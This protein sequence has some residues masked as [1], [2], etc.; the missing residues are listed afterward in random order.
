MA[1]QTIAAMA[2]LLAVRGWTLFVPPYE[3]QANGMWHEAAY[4]ARTN[5]DYYSLRWEEAHYFFGGQNRHY[6]VSLLPTILAILMKTLPNA[7]SVIFCWRFLGLLFAAVIA[8]Q[9]YH[10]ARVRASAATTLLLVALLFT[11]PMFLV[12]V[13]LAGMELPVIVFALIASWYVMRERYVAASVASLLSFLMKATGGLVTMALLA[14]LG[15]LI[16]L[17]RRT[18]KEWSGLLASGTVLAIQMLALYFG[19]DTSV[20]RASFAW[21]EALKLPASIYW[22]PDVVVLV[23]TTA[24]ITGVVAVRWLLATGPPSSW[25]ATLRELARQRPAALSLTVFHWILIIGNIL[26]TI[27]YLFIPRYFTLGLVLTYVNVGL[28]LPKQSRIARVATPVLVVGIWFNL[29]NLY[30]QLFPPTESASPVEFATQPLYYSRFCAFSERSLEYIADQQSTNRAI[31]LIERRFSDHPIFID[32]PL[33]IFLTRPFL[34]VVQKAPADVYLGEVYLNNIREFRK[35]VLAD[36][37]GKDFIFVLVGKGRTRFVQADQADEIL[38]DDQLSPPL[39]VY[40]VDRSQLPKTPREIEDWYLDHSWSPEFAMCRAT[41]RQEFLV[42]SGRV[43]RAIEEFREA[44]LLHP[45]ED[46]FYRKLIEDASQRMADLAKRSVLVAGQWW[47]LQTSE[48]ATGVISSLPGDPMG[49]RVI[50]ETIESSEPWKV[51]LRGQSQLVQAASEYEV[52]FRARAERPHPVSLAFYQV[53][54][55]PE[56][57]SQYQTVAVTEKWQEHRLVFTMT[58]TDDAALSFQL[59]SAAGWVELA[60]VVIQPTSDKR[61]D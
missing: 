19:D 4:L 30:G 58:K 37:D 18:G 24:C 45:K 41:E 60:D 49:I 51:R 17:G 40:R 48:P 59:G 6:M 25:F 3:E 43:G 13:D 28:L 21:P 32:R 22:C 14:Y 55:S 26:S 9:T 44:L 53:F 7:Q 16:L 61:P 47:T 52:R 46:R 10:L 31:R 50:S 34:G 2:V 42:E 27:P 20:F 35:R 1:C 11:T 39:L 54:G 8:V 36:P 12:Q 57:M 5:F 56:I 33:W 29:C 23:A 38:Y 15:A